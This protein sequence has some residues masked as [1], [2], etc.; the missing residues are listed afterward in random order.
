MITR[1]RTAITLALMFVVVTSCGGST[2]PTQ[3]LSNF[4]PEI[5]NGA[6]SF[7]FQATALTQVGATVVYS[8]QN[9]GTQAS[10]DHSS[11]ITSGTAILQIFDHDNVQV[12]SDLLLASGSDQTAVGVAGE[13][14]VRVTLT[15]VD[16]TLNFR[17]E[18]L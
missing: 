17:A 9:S 13:W 4:Q 6:D 5:V 1:V 2:R 16:G 11:A 14:E 15:D 8:W 3:P 7:E 10:I 18:T 12:Y